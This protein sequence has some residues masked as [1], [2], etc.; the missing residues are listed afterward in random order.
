MERGIW[1]RSKNDKEER[2]SG[3]RRKWGRMERR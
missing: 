2:E 1:E 3:I